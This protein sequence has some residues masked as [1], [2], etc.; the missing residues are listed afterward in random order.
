MAQMMAKDLSDREW[1]IGRGGQ[2][3]SFEAVFGPRGPDGKPALLWDRQT[4]KI[5]PKIAEAWRKY[6]IRHIVETNWETLGPKLKGK[7]YLYCGD[8]D[9]FF[10]EL[11]F[12]KLRD[13]LKRLGS[14]AYIEVIPGASHMLPPTIYNKVARQMA[15]KSN[16]HYTER[17][18]G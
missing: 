3:G 18:G 4:G 5:D 2:M 15:D 6:D 12:Y 11:A 8:R 14:D 10:L 16:R 9:T 7:L 13:A 1:V 17:R